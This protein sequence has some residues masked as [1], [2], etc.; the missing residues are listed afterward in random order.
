MI[1]AG[2]VV[3]QAGHVLKGYGVG[4]LRHVRVKP[5][6]PHFTASD[7]GAAVVFF[8]SQQPLDELHDGA[9]PQ[10]ATADAAAAAGAISNSAADPG[11]EELRRRTPDVNAIVDAIVAHMGV[12]LVGVDVLVAPDGR[13]LVIDV[14][15]FSG[16]PKTVPGFAGALAQLVRRAC[17]SSSSNTSPRAA[18]TAQRHKADDASTLAADGSVRNST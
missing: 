7:E 15:H 10:L 17:S 16:A 6:I 14:N 3:A 5:S 11:L 2:S 13:C 4:S 8:D 12:Q 18:A 9:P 1:T